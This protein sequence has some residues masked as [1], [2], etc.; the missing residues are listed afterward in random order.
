LAQ[1]TQ[2]DETVVL[3]Q[4]GRRRGAAR[5]VEATTAP[6]FA[7]DAQGLASSGDSG[8]SDTPSHPRTTLPFVHG[9]ST[10]RLTM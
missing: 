8:W 7:R 6:C 2:G 3:L 4:P 1:E 9:W 5:M 10:T